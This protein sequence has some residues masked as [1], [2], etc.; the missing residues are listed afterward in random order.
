MERLEQRLER[1]WWQWPQ[2]VRC[3]M[4]RERV[5]PVLLVDEL[6]LI[7]K[8]HCI[9]IKSDSQLV[10]VPAGSLRA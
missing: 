2:S 1:A 4:G 6:R 5:K 7:G 8:K 3:F 9:P 10:R